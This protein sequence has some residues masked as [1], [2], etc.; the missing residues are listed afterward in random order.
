MYEAQPNQNAA[1]IVDVSATEIASTDAH[2]DHA[3]LIPHNHGVNWGARTDATFMPSGKAIPSM[4]PDGKRVAIAT[5]IRTLVAAASV[6]RA[7]H[8]SASPVD[9]ST[10]TNMPSRMTPERANDL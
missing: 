9:A 7:I 3:P 6:D 10:I 2:T 1:E 4:M 5:P 8:G